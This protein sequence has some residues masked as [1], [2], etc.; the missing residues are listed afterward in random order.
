MDWQAFSPSLVVERVFV[1]AA[2]DL[3]WETVDEAT[4]AYE[5][6]RELEAVAAD[7]GLERVDEGNA[8]DGVDRE[9]EAVAADLG[10]ETVDEATSADGEFWPRGDPGWGLLMEPPGNE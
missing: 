6:D 3:G 4:A 9:L 1:A 2:A 5:V 10:W 7:L 8:A